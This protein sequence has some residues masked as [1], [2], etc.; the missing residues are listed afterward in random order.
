MGAE[1]GEVAVLV[2]IVELALAEG[3]EL[4][5]LDPVDRVAADAADELG[6][7]DDDDVLVCDAPVSLPSCQA[8][9]GRGGESYQV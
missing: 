3:E 5:R 8:R 7:G 4:G 1:E 6:F 2:R 9:G